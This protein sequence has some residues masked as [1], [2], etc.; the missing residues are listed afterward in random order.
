MRRYRMGNL[1][2]KTIMSA[3]T[4][5]IPDAQEIIRA[6]SNFHKITIAF[7]RW[8]Q[9]NRGAEP[10]ITPDK[11]HRK[12]TTIAIEEVEQGLVEFSR[13]DEF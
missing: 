5:P 11:S 2:G 13:T 10:R 3:V 7:L 12:N 4:I 9:L 8:K 1:P 6:G